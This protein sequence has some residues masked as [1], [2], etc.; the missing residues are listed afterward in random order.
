MVFS[1]RIAWQKGVDLFVD[2]CNKLHYRTEAT[3]EIYGKSERD[4]YAR[5]VLDNLPQYIRYKQGKAW[6]AR[7]QIFENAGVI[8]VPSRSEP[9]G[10]IIL[11]AMEY[12]VPVI[13]SSSAGAGEFIDGPLKVDETNLVDDATAHTIRLLTD[14]H[15]WNSIVRAQHESL[16]RFV[17]TYDARGIMRV[18]DRLG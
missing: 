16:D 4:D 14:E 12:G 3:F 17:G 5:D 18:W 11:E 9:F 2:I 7:E 10:M 13:F 6:T 15:H 8:I 1:G